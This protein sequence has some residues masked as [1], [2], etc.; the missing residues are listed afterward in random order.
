MV[1][2]L[3]DCHPGQV[4]EILDLAV[5]CTVTRAEHLELNKCDEF[6]GWERYRKAGIRV[7]DVKGSQLRGETQF[8]PETP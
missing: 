2:K 5:G 8:S 6:D 1:R 3:L 7:V 4:D